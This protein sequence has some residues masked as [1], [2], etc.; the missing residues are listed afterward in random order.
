MTE[1][2]KVAVLGS[3]EFGK[4]L[5]MKILPVQLEGKKLTLDTKRFTIMTGIVVGLVA[6]IQLIMAPTGDAGEKPKVTLAELGTPS[7]GQEIQHASQSDL[8]GVANTETKKNSVKF[9]GASIIARPIDLTKIPPGSILDAKLITGASNGLVRAEATS[10]LSSAGE[11]LI[12]KGSILVGNGNS[13][14]ERLFVRFNQVVFKDGAIAAL[15]AHAC[16]KS[17]KIVGLK[18]SKVGTKALNIAGSLGL[19][20]LGGFS[21]ALQESEGQ[22]GAVVRKPS[23]KNAL[24]N[25]TATTALEQS[26]NL[27]SDLKDR[28]PIIEV[29]AGTEICVIAAGSQQ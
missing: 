29:D 15:E 14:D 6:A 23:I 16:D 8:K 4:K 18:G 1:G 13:T 3:E 11:L 17:D 5:W 12:P 24:L 25:G 21:E 20:F 19:G 28:T 26:K 2:A 27:M 9:A 7:G 22:Q 10:S